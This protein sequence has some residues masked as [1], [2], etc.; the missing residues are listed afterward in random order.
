MFLTKYGSLRALRGALYCNLRVNNRPI[1]AYDQTA[2]MCFWI[3]KIGLLVLHKGKIFNQRTP[4]AQR[5]S[6]S[7]WIIKSAILSGQD[8]Q[9]FCAICCVQRV[10]QP[11]RSLA[12]CLS[13]VFICRENGP[14]SLSDTLRT[15]LYTF[16]C[17][18][19]LNVHW[20]T[21]SSP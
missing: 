11:S 16:Q 7:F 19:G 1:H 6:R 4:M 12:K 10:K 13:W 15:R 9:T 18:F 21:L 20:M 2:F 3:V 5:L 8:F 17:L 14:T